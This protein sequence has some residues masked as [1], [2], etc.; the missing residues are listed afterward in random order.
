[1]ACN[2]VLQ[3]SQRVVEDFAMTSGTQRDGRQPNYKPPREPLLFPPAM[4]RRCFRFASSGV[5]RNQNGKPAAGG[6]V[7]VLR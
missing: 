1:M 2:R 5:N 7:Q 4:Q 6:L 3:S